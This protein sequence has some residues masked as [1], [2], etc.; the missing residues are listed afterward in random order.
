MLCTLGF[1]S[2]S[3]DRLCSQREVSNTKLHFCRSQAVYSPI[4]VKNIV[5]VYTDFIPYNRG[6]LLLRVQEKI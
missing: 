3:F 6:N 1:V 5:T 2:I 4:T